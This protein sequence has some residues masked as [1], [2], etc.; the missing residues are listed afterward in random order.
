MSSSTKRAIIC[1]V[2]GGKNYSKINYSRRMY[3][4]MRRYTPEVAEGGSNECFA[5]LTGLRT[6]FKMTYKDLAEKIL[7]D[8]NTEIGVKFI[9][10]VA[11]AEEY[12]IAKNKNKR[13][14]S[15]TTYKEMNSLFAG[16]S[17]VE[18]KRRKSLTYKSKKLV[19]PFLGKVA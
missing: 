19:I 9:V 10:Q 1:V 17:F 7:Y 4:I 5:D 15:I 12:D 6:F 16:S 8:L 2:T 13:T 3:A 18:S 14:K 11:T